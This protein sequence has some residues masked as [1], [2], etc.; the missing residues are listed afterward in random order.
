MIHTILIF[1]LATCSGLALIALIA[2][3]ICAWKDGV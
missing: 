1:V 2:S 3:E